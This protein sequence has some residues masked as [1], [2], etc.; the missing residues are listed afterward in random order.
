MSSIY[1]LFRTVKNFLTSLL[2]L[3]P[4]LRAGHDNLALSLWH[5]NFLSAGGTA[6]NMMGFPLSHIRFETGKLI[7]ELVPDSQKL[8][9]FL[10]ALAVISGEQ[11]IVTEDNQCQNQP[12]PD[13]ASNKETQNNQSKLHVYQKTRQFV[14]ASLSISSLHKSGKFFSHISSPFPRFSKTFF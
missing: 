11:P 8:L 5:A 10:V 3:R 9:I 12:C 13:G 4:A 2:K 7:G 14:C 1:F 6:V